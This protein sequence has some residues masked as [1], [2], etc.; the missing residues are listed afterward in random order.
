MALSSCRSGSSGTDGD[1]VRTDLAPLERRFTAL[2]PLS[3]A[4][5]LS[6]VMGSD[7]RVPA[8]GPTDVR[9]VGLAR[10]RAGRVATLAGAP[11]WDFQ[12]E[13]PDQPPG[14]LTQFMPQSARWVRSESFDREMTSDTDYGAFHFDSGTDSVYFD[15]INPRPASSSGP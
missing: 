7:S 9:V 6:I 10:L 1:K 3:D 11:Q 4:H 14:V 12:P 15:T 8:P 5:W 13:K 2:G